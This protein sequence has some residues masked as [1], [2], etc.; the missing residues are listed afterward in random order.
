MQI[1][2][3]FP[4]LI[5][6]IFVNSESLILRHSW[7]NVNRLRLN[8]ERPFFSFSKIMFKVLGSL[9]AYKVIELDESAHFK[10]WERLAMLTPITK[11][12]LHLY[13][14]KP[15]A[16]KLRETRATW[17]VS[18]ASMKIPSEVILRLTSFTKSLIASTILYKIWLSYNFASNI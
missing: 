16:S 5:V 18:M 1:F 7:F 17:E 2:E 15:S 10:T 11:S 14:S 9:S 6:M 3:N 12:L 4:E 8:I 13:D